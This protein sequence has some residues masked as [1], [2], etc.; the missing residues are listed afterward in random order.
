MTDS[1]FGMEYW[2]SYWLEFN[3]SKEKEINVWLNG[4]Q[5]ERYFSWFILKKK[6]SS[7]NHEV[8]K[9]V[10]SHDFIRVNWILLQLSKTFY[11]KNR[12]KLKSIKEKHKK[13]VLQHKLLPFFSTS[14]RFLYALELARLHPR[15]KSWL[16]FINFKLAQSMNSCLYFSEIF[17]TI[18]I[19]LPS[20][21][22]MC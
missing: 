21:S 8:E 13:I 17:F 10:V 22:N 3:I 6:K 19:I 18:D 5:M 16:F 7:T 9:W 12:L 20:H 1:Q 4:N 14:I 11:I 2:K 15:N